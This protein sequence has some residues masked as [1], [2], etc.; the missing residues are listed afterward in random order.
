M[1]RMPLKIQ[2]DKK[3]WN[4]GLAKGNAKSK[5]DGAGLPGNPRQMEMEMHEELPLSRELELSA[6]SRNAAATR[7][8]MEQPGEGVSGE[9]FGKRSRIFGK[10]H[11]TEKGEKDL[12]SRRSPLNVSKDTETQGTRCSS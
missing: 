3:G 9:G 10:E 1:P 12:P 7:G 8:K 6:W 4:T 2:V 5:C 11:E